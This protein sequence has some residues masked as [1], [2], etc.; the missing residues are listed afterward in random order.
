MPYTFFQLW[1]FSCSLT[2]FET[3]NLKPGRSSRIA[4]F[5]FRF[6]LLPLACY[7]NADAARRALD[8]GYRRRHVA[9]VQVGHFQLGDLFHLPFGHFA[10]FVAIGFAGTLGDSRRAL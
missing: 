10:H 9:R 2:K 6:S 4:S 7:F 8:G 5:E 3:R 1:P